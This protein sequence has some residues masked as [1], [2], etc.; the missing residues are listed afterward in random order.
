[1]F[2]LLTKLETFSFFF[3][4]FFFFFNQTG[5]AALHLAAERGHLDVAQELLEQRA[6][7]NAKTKVLL[8]CLGVG[9]FTFLWKILNVQDSRHLT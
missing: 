4:F 3:F 5:K 7:V 6:Y 9:L 2:V 1:M 8:Y